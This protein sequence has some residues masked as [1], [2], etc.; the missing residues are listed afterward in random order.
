V[1][2]YSY[3]RTEDGLW[4]PQAA[5]HIGAIEPQG[6]AIDFLDE[7][8]LVLTS[9]ALPGRPGPIHRVVCP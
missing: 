4:F 3:L 1:D 5:C 7:E 8:T 6:E 2:I 9:E